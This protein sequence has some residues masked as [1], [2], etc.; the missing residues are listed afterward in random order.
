MLHLISDTQLSSASKAWHVTPAYCCATKH[1]H[2]LQTSQP[3]S[4][5]QCI[6]TLLPCVQ[7][8]PP[9]YRGWV[10]EQVSGAARL[11]H[12]HMNNYYEAMVHQGEASSPSARQVELVTLNLTSSR[13]HNH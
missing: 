2:S 6:N 13:P 12:E 5:W 9:Q 8:V 7:G 1:S 11:M 4:S 3:C 10:W